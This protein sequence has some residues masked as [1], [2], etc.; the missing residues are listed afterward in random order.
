M[1]GLGWVMHKV[2][3]LA[4]GK[5]TAQLILTACPDQ[6]VCAC[7]NGACQWSTSNS[8]ISSKIGSMQELDS[9]MPASNTLKTPLIRKRQKE[10]KTE[11]SGRRY[12]E[13]KKICKNM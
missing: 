11:L 5:Y 4:T 7:E 8:D 3:F 1:I 2:E 12:K 13:L 9:K 6:A 10:R